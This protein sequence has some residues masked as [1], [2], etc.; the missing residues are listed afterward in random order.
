MDFSPAWLP[1]HPHEPLR[2]R[3]EDKVVDSK[4]PPEEERRDAQRVLKTLRDPSATVQLCPV[5]FAGQPA[6]VI[7][8]FLED[9]SIF[10]FVDPSRLDS[11]LSLEPGTVAAEPRRFVAG[12]SVP[13]ALVLTGPLLRQIEWPSSWTRTSAGSNQPLDPTGGG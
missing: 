8:V 1:T 5:T 6:T 3:K 9:P 11:L 7:Y 13:L 10:E 12:R 2:T 4:P